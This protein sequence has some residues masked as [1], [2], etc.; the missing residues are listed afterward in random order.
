MTKT[1]LNAELRIRTDPAQMNNVITQISK[2]FEMMSTDSEALPHERLF[3]VMTRK[4]P[5]TLPQISVL[6]FDF[7]DIT[8]VTPAKLRSTFCNPVYA[9]LEPYSQSLVDD[10]LWIATAACS[11]RCNPHL[12]S[13]GQS[14]AP[15]MC[16]LQT[17]QAATE[18][19]HN[20]ENLSETALI[21]F[22][23]GFSLL[24]H[25]EVD[26]APVQLQK[27]LGLAKRTGDIS[28]EA[29][30]L[31]YLAIIAR[32]R[33]EIEHVREYVTQSLAAA[34]GGHMVEYIGMAKMHLVWIALRDKG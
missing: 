16:S 14:A 17:A 33:G 22:T 31:A 23:L 32:K 30:A 6:M 12:V 19:I 26:A 20:I 25:D 8:P 21:N 29:R 13:K 7:G 27:T 4:P 10:E 28:V 11:I 5:E 24:W 18:A 2:E 9:G 15:T 1:M 3:T 34:T